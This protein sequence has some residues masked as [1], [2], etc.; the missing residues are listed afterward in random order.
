MIKLISPTVLD[1]LV[2][3]LCTDT[4][5]LQPLHIHYLDYRLDIHASNPGRS[6]GWN[7]FAGPDG[8][9]VWTAGT[10]DRRKLHWRL[11][12]SGNPKPRPDFQ[13]SNGPDPIL[14]LDTAAGE[15]EFANI[16]LA[17]LWQDEEVLY[18]GYRLG[19]GP[20]GRN[21]WF[22]RL[23]E[24][25][26]SREVDV[27]ERLGAD[28]RAALLHHF[29]ETLPDPEGGAAPWLIL[30]RVSLTE[31]AAPLDA[32]AL[33]TRLWRSLLLSIVI[34]ERLRDESLKN[35]RKT[36]PPV[37][38]S[39]MQH[40]LNQILFGPP[41]T[42]KTYQSIAYAVAII[43][44]EN[45]QDVMAQPRADVKAR[46][47]KYRQLGQ[48]A[49][50]TFHQSF[51]YEDFVEG[52][53]PE[54]D[55]ESDDQ[56]RYTIE[57][58]IFRR[59]SARAIGGL[60][61]QHQQAE[62]PSGKPDFDTLYGLF[63]AHLEQQLQT[64]PHVLLPSKAGGRIA[65]VH[66]NTRRNSLKMT[67]LDGNPEYFYPV[68]LDR[69][70][71]LYELYD[72]V[73]DI[74][75]V[76]DIGEAIGGSGSTLYWS[77]FKA[78]KDF[79]R[80]LPPT[81]MARAVAPSPT[82]ETTLAQAEAFDFGKL[83]AADYAAAPRFVLLI[84][85]INRGNVASIFGELITLLEADKRAGAE[86]E[87]RITLPYSKTTFTVP[88][89]LYLLGTMNTA[90]RSVEALD[91]ALRRRFTFVEMPPEPAAISRQPN[92]GIVDG[93]DV[94]RLLETLNLRLET[95]LDHDHQLGHAWLLGITTLEQLQ[96]AF[97]GKIIPQLQEYFFGNWARIGAVLGAGFVQK[98]PAVGLAAGFEPEDG[99]ELKPRYRITPRATWTAAAFRSVYAG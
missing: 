96:D 5:A 97:A 60:A 99:E 57:A 95:L 29:P 48:I 89:N 42:G 9:E 76:S 85:E 21:R 32:A 82:D 94:A 69:F 3:V 2:A 71:R 87:L 7:A 11:L 83:T 73:E 13:S 25:K 72:S 92:G 1:Q 80:T 58:G 98:E 49:F 14:Q 90:D 22:G 77:A 27:T 4:T 36:T 28:I 18:W 12:P 62:P 47:E 86:N 70:R 31:L 68:T 30:E 88:P 78:L 17:R 74:K 53:K 40:P 81:A 43:A 59:M 61:H 75:A 50:T 56:L 23:R 91:T 35:P 79:E 64:A 20:S 33:K 66:V 54:L 24:G 84:D 39:P 37:S 41:G 51:S 93:V 15:P 63:A 16:P 45:P 34:G 55:Q 38:S 8:A 67:F 65:V 46:F 6:P 10:T 19:N 52:I 26:E 44:G